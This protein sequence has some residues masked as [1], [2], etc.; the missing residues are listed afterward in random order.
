MTKRISL[1]LKLGITFFPIIFSWFTLKKCYSR[2]SRILSFSWIIISLLL[3]VL[4]P[5]LFLAALVIFFFILD[6]RATPSTITSSSVKLSPLEPA[7]QYVSPLEPASHYVSPVKPAAQYV[8]PVEPASQYAFNYIDSK[9]QRSRRNV[10]FRSVD[11]N[12]FSGHIY[13]KGICTTRNASRT[14]K[15]VNMNNLVNVDTGECLDDPFE[16]FESIYE[17]A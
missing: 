16:H 13:L 15:V 5:L 6:R 12:E 17:S 2:N 14:F 10:I 11:L 1:P 4:N 7:S 3:P 9:S 8:S